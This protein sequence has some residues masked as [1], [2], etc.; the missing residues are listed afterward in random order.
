AGLVGRVRDWIAPRLEELG[1]VLS[2]GGEGGTLPAA[3]P[4]APGSPV[5][6]ALVRGDL[7]IAATGTVTWVDG[8]RIY[9]FG[10]PLFGS[11]RVELPMVAAEVVHTL[12]DQ[13]GSVRL[14][15]T[16]EELGA[17]VDDRLTAIVGRTDERA[18]LLPVVLEV[19]GAEAAPHTFRFEVARRSS[20][21][22]V[23]VGVAVSNALLSNV[24]YEREATMVLHGVLRLVGRAELPL[25]LVAAGRDAGHPGFVLGTALQQLLATLN[26]NPFGP[27]ELGGLELQVEARP[28]VRRYGVESVRFDRAPLVPGQLLRV[29]VDLQP[30]R[31]PL[32]RERLELRVPEHLPRGA[33]LSLVV[34]SPAYLERALGQ[35]VQGR[36]DSAEDLEALLRALAAR[37]AGLRLEAALVLPSREI[38]ARG[39]V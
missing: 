14:A 22:P 27:V 38:V 25:E 24:A 28:Q 18:A 9:A 31:G 17:I 3:L 12:A 36:I 5:G 6:V 16:G 35:P 21:T 4:L 10:H 1:F 7:S 8:E 30:Y 23:L 39:A 34:G 19:T 26:D 20:L 29:D 32:R 11:G 33:S 2:G 37:E 15:R 13:L